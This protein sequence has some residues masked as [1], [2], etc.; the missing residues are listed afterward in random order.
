MTESIISKILSG[1][2]RWL[3]HSHRGLRAKAE[4]L[5]DR[6]LVPDY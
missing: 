3:V 1:F 2:P 5:V 6:E 4:A